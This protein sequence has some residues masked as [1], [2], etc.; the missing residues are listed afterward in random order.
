MRLTG[1]APVPPQRP[2]PR[3][4]PQDRHRP[5]NHSE[6]A[7]SVAPLI[8]QIPS[9][10]IHQPPQVIHHL[11]T[12]SAQLLPPHGPVMLLGGDG[13]AQGP[14]VASERPPEHKYKEEKDPKENHG[15]F[16]ELLGEALVVCCVVARLHC[17]VPDTLQRQARA[18]AH[19]HDAQELEDKVPRA[20]LEEDG[21]RYEQRRPPHERES[22][23]GCQRPFEGQFEQPL[24]QVE[25]QTPI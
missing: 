8:L 16:A 10:L 20:E 14:D 19:E 25:R 23:A 4:L 15:D 18:V 24:Q 22:V 21:D 1:L 9:D 2:A 3:P 5:S 11:R 17:V 12:C 6:R 13:G 7:D